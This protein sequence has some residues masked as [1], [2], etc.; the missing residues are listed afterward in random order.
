MGSPVDDLYTRSSGTSMAA[1][2]AT[3]A[4]ALLLQAKPE[5]TPLQVKER[6]AKAARTLGL[7]PNVQ[8][9]GLSD[10]YAAYKDES[11][12]GPGPGPTPG[13]GCLIALLNLLLRQ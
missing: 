6:L 8:G 13:T 4:V 2:F 9:A 10:I 3:G 12:P 5:L 11:T 1:P 7:D